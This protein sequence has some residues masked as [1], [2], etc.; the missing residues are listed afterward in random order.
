[1]TVYGSKISY[2]TGKLETYLRFR[3]LAYK[4][5]PTTAGGQGKLRE[6]TGVAQMPVVHLS[7]DRWMTD[8]TPMIAWLDRHFEGPSVYP[9]DRALRFVALLIEDYAD[10]WLWR[11]AM[12]YRWSYRADREYASQSLYAELIAGIEPIPR[13]AAINYLKFRQYG[14]FVFGDGVRGQARQ[15]ADQTYLNILDRL[16]A[17]FLKRR[18]LLGDAPTIADFGMMAPMLRHFG[19]DPTPAEIMRNRAPNVYEWVARMWNLRSHA[20][21]GALMEAI[22]A[23]LRDL[24]TEVSETHLAQL[25]QNA[26]AFT[27]G[28]K[29]YDL[30]VQGATY[31]RVPTSRYR[32]WCL[33]T[34]RTEWAA[35]SPD[36]QAALQAH[37]SSP[38]ATLLWEPVEFAASSYDHE[39]LAPFNR[40]IHVYGTGIPS[41]L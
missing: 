35:L 1:M 39:Q 38:E 16:E 12:H 11:S 30:N 41:P 36:D 20:P 7:D 21:H 33:E 19:Q 29:R 24:L 14:G 3:G 17:I 10:E 2:Y 15:H 6:Q 32:L 28:A 5:L 40:A 4:V 31:R 27:Q 22:D 37:L 13:F 25:R 26:A 9:T 8:T 34:L 18:F 23:P